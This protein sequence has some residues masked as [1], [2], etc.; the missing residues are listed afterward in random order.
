MIENPDLEALLS[1]KRTMLNFPMFQ[2]EARSCLMSSFAA[3]LQ[4]PASPIRQELTFALRVHSEDDL[5]NIVD[6]NA[7]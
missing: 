3:E 6:G 1:L 5:D 2:P 4:M 7:C